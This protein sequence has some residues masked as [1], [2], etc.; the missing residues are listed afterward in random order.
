MNHVC[1][2][3]SRAINVQDKEI[4]KKHVKYNKKRDDLHQEPY[5]YFK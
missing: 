2:H 1:D 5:Y 4:V 3:D